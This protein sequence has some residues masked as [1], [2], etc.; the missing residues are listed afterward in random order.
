MGIPAPLGTQL[1][2]MPSTPP[3]KRAKNLETVASK[4]TLNMSV[5][6]P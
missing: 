5:T 3:I 4:L 6:S 1:Q 2:V